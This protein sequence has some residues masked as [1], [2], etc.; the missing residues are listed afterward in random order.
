[1]TYHVMEE[2]IL[3]SAGSII[4]STIIGL[5]AFYFISN[6]AKVQRKQQID[7]IA[8]MLINFAIY[9]WLSKLLLNIQ[10][11]IAD[12]FA[13]LAFPSD[14]KAFYL[15]CL[16]VGVHMIYKSRRQQMN[17]N[18]FIIGFTPFF[19]ISSLTY[20]F[21]QFVFG[22][23]TTIGYLIFLAYLSILFIWLRDVI[24]EAMITKIVWVVWSSGVLLIS[25]F[26]PFVTVFGYLMKPWFL[27]ILFVGSGLWIFFSRK[28][29]VV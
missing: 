12:P 22:K 26:L 9:I 4:L 13:A 1:M 29:G 18:E 15:A 10:L 6:L 20:E 2:R 23:S 5:L 8:S 25:L 24:S 14:S 11:F 17:V 28:K 19:M 7:N 27:V 16:F 3:S 21:I